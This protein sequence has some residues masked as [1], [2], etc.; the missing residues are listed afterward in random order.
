MK[1]KRKMGWS[2][3]PSSISSASAPILNSLRDFFFL[4][5]V[6]QGQEFSYMS[7][8][9]PA[10]LCPGKFFSLL[11][12][13]GWES[14][15]NSKRHKEETFPARCGCDVSQEPGGWG[16]GREAVPAQSVP[17]RPS[18]ATTGT[19]IRF[20]FFKSVWPLPWS[21]RTRARISAL[22]HSHTHAHAW[23]PPGRQLR[24]ALPAALGFL[25]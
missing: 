24:R 16:R 5:K 10:S 7:C 15:P 2:L 8:L 12:L 20:Y 9:P 23:P 6:S 25:L 11:R 1:E 14:P 18:L 3:R 21:T 19:G 22:T 13:W 4:C 17:S